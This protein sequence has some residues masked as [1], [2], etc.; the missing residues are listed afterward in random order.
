MRVPEG[1]SLKSITL[2]REIK[3]LHSFS[4]LI[5]SLFTLKSITLER[6]IKTR[7]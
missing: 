5:G 3:T 1:Y 6:E 4:V 2:E 7:E